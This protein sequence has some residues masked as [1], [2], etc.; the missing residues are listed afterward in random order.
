MKVGAFYTKNVS[1][2]TKGH[3]WG[4]VTAGECIHA[5]F[6]VNITKRLIQSSYCGEQNGSKTSLSATEKFYK[7][8][9]SIF[10]EKKI[11]HF[12]NS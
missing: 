11:E 12:Y 8:W 1:V 4:H 5:L 10:K 3:A 7:N 2:F 6:T 9:I